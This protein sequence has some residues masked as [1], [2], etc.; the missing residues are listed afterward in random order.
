MKQESA[1]VIDQ[2]WRE[3]VPEG[4]TTTKPDQTNLTKYTYIERVDYWEKQ[5]PDGFVEQYNTVLSENCSPRVA[6]AVCW[7]VAG[8]EGQTSRCTQA[9]IADQFETSARTI[10]KYHMHISGK[11]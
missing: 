9:E 3:T 11:A 1:E 7:Y 5:I 10:R 8:L 6:A 4:E 2:A